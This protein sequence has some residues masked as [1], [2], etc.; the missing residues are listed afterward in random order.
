[1]T[2][3]YVQSR[4]GQA[5]VH[6]ARP[7]P[8]ALPPQG[9]ASHAGG[10]RRPIVCLH[11]QPLSARLLVPLVESLGRTRLAI[12]PDLPGYGQS[13]APASAPSMDEY[14]AAVV[15]VAAACGIGEFDVA[16]C[17]TGSR[18]AVAVAL[19]RPDLVKHVVLFGALVTTAEQRASAKAH[20]PPAPAR[21]GTS[22]LAAWKQWMGSWPE[23]APMDEGCDLFADM[24]QRLG[25]PERAFLVDA[26]HRFLLDEQVPKLPQPLLVINTPGPLHALT[27][28]IAPY[29]RDGELADVPRDLFGLLSRGHADEACDA[30]TAFVD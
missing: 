13:D 26:A 4:F 6:V 16:G 24:L 25:R 18:V 30:V 22:I 1:M 19:A 15:E 20:L 29:I 17:L 11:P 3:C 27:A 5:H 23:D 10:G 12:A 7:A 21:D 14:A 9:I 2:R 28:R 8:Q